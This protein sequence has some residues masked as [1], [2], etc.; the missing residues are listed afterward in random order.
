[1]ANDHMKGINALPR[2]DPS[3]PTRYSYDPKNYN[4]ADYAT[5]KQ[6]RLDALEKKYPTAQRQNPFGRESKL[7]RTLDRDLQKRINQA[8]AKRAP[9]HATLNASGVDSACLESLTWKDG[10]AHATFIKRDPGGG[11][12]YDMDRDTFIEWVNSGSLGRWG[13]DNVF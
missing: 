7:N 5:F 3:N 2:W 9:K 4:A 11:Y 10:V 13:N 8:V 12:F 1:M 6:A